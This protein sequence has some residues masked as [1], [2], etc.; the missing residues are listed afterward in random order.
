MTPEEIELEVEKIAR[1]C[2]YEGYMQSKKWAIKRRLK[3]LSTNYTCEICGY[4]GFDEKLVDKTL[5][6][7]HI[8]YERLG[9]E[10]MD[11]LKVLCRNCHE[12]LHNRSFR[13]RSIR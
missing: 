12:K 10:N 7:H 13:E 5:D 6:V 2:K 1:Q 8:T 4:S 3:L 11:D 9:D